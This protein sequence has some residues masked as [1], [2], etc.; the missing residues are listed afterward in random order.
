MAELSENKIGILGGTF[1]PI[2]LGH[3]I[4][5]QNALETFDLDRVLLIPCAHPPHKNSSGL[6]AAEH[7]KAMADMAVEGDPSLEV[8][9]IEIQRG[10]VSYT[11]DTLW[12]LSRV[13]PGAAFHFIIGSDTLTELHLWKEVNKI[14]EMCT[15][16]TF[17]RPGFD[18]RAVEPASLELQPPWPERLL[19]NV[20]YGK[21]IDISS[22]DI[23]YRVMEGM[24]IHYLVP[25]AVEMYI[26]EHGLYRERRG[27]GG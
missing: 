27:S 3:L 1:N 22:S 10:G 24:S 7:R 17:A 13:Y 9:D 19:Q 4:L 21:Q 16:V 8:S 6:A 11:V 18:L 5:A 25:A 20:S 23:R 12:Q 15:V 14:L 2:H 26:G